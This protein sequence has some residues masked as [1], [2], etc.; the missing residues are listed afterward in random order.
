MHPVGSAGEGTYE[1]LRTFAND[2][3]IEFATLLGYRPTAWAWPQDRR[4]LELASF[5]TRRALCALPNRTPRQPKTPTQKIARVH[6]LVRDDDV[7]ATVAT[8]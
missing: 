8:A 2:V 7:A 6:D 1:T 4:Q 3:G 5:T